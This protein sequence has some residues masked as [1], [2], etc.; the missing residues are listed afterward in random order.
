MVD[1]ME[2]STMKWLHK[3]GH[4]D[5]EIAALTGRDRHTVAQVLKEPVDQTYQRDAK[6]SR[7][8]P[9]IASI[10]QWLQQGLPT[11]RMLEKA[12][13]ESEPPYTGGKSV[14]YARVRALRQELGRLD[15]EVPLRFE[16]RPG[17][18]AQVDWGEQKVPFLRGGLQKVYFLA[19][20]LKFSRYA[21]VEFL[22]NTRL[23]TL[24]RGLLRAFES[25]GGVPWAVVFDNMKTVTTGRD[26][27]GQPLLHPTFAQFAAD[28]DFH[29]ELCAPRSPQ[30]KGSVENLVR[31]VKSNFFPGRSFVERADVEGQGRA[32]RERINHQTNQAH[33]Q[34]PAELLV[35]ERAQLTPLPPSAADYGLLHLARVSWAESVV[36]FAANRYS[37]P[38]EYRGQAVAV[39][40]HEQR[41]KMYAQD[42]LIADHP[43]CFERGQLILAPAHFAAVLRQKPRGKVML[44]RQQLLDLGEPVRG[45]ITEV[46]RRYR[47][48]FGGH[49]VTLYELWQ[50]GST[51]AF[52]AAVEAA[53]AAEAF[54]AEYVR[55]LLAGPGEEG[56]APLPGWTGLPSQEDLDRPLEGY[57]AFVEGAVAGPW[58]PAGR[59]EEGPPE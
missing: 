39:R 8:D 2:R 41:V 56:V 17:E 14:F 32:W 4:S 6:G 28:L 31:F 53:Q 3:H 55:A 23:E 35:Q 48:D 51:A 29:P 18:Y 54:G 24:L 30:Q 10:E 38:V 22:D 43:R 34:I 44:Y 20:R 47:T 33:D 15:G 5:S 13:E 57:E 27:Q 19:V 58:E 45:Y 59:E 21:W 36:Y 7:V 42:H 25:F 11:Q 9:F 1:Q 49:I 40:W 50:G 46:C 26:S 52:G 16:G 37:A 12:R